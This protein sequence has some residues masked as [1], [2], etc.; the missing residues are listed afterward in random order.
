MS[1]VALLG[2]GGR[3]GPGVHKDIFLP[4]LLKPKHVCLVRAIAKRSYSKSR[5]VSN[6]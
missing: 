6:R 1:L 4:S 3:G 5:T 2:V